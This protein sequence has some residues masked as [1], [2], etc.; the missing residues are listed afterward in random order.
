[1]EVK[2]DAQLGSHQRGV[3]QPA[4]G[5]SEVARKR[6]GSRLE[7]RTTF[8]TNTAVRTVEVADGAGLVGG[9][10]N[11]PPKGVIAIAGNLVALP[12]FNFA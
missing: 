12:V 5:A 8:L 4:A 9:L 2:A 11:T 10:A 3:A 1:M 6:G 7:K